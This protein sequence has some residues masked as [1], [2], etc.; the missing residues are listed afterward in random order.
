MERRITRTPLRRRYELL[1]QDWAFNLNLFICFLLEFIQV[2]FNFIGHSH[3]Y[4][5]EFSLRFNAL[6]LRLR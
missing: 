5:F 6:H 2:I 3:I 4:S 1:S